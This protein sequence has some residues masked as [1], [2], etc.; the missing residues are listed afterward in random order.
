MYRYIE[1]FANLPA[2][3]RIVYLSSSS[4]HSQY[5]CPPL[6]SVQSHRTLKKLLIFF[7]FS[8]CSCRYFSDF[9]FVYKSRGAKYSTENPTI[10]QIYDPSNVL[11]L[12]RYLAI[13]YAVSLR[14]RD[15]P[16]C[17][18]LATYMLSTFGM[19]QLQNKDHI[20]IFVC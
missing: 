18:L 9:L 6:L 8:F 1:H 13:C 3:R 2:A 17:G 14:Q 5:R 10:S 15:A 19:L 11:F 7:L 4:S 12:L 20:Y 16:L